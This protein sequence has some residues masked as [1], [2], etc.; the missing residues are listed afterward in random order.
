[1]V[2]LLLKFCQIHRKMQNALSR[3]LS[4]FLKLPNIPISSIAVKSIDQ[5]IPHPPSLERWAG[6]GPH[7]P[8]SAA[9]PL[10]VAPQ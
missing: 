2:V 7:G 5:V 6:N 3:E 8:L 10:G 1:M 4:R 9:F